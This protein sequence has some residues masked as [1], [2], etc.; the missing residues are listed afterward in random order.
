MQAVCKGVS[1]HMCVYVYVCNRWNERRNGGER[2][3]VQEQFTLTISKT[4]TY[5]R[6]CSVTDNFCGIRQILLSYL[7]DIV[8]SVQL[9][10]R[11]INYSLGLYD[12]YLLLSPLAQT[13]LSK[14]CCYKKEQHTPNPPSPPLFITI[15]KCPLNPLE[16]KTGIFTH[17]L[18]TFSDIK[19]TQI[20][21]EQAEFFLPFQVNF[22]FYALRTQ[23]YGP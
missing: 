19:L 21:P 23:T 20:Q 3:I 9:L 16:F 15:L 18:C 10:H 2:E 5:N 8:I 6:W 12:C 1:V 17:T 14:L 13:A 11:F 7:R 22:M 4:I